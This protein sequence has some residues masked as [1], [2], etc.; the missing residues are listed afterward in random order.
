MNRFENFRDGGWFIRGRWLTVILSLAFV[1]T[2]GYGAAGLYF[3][4][5]YKTFFA[6]DNP[7]RLAYENIQDRFLKSDNVLFVLTA[8]DGD[9]YRPEFLQAVHWLTERAWGLHRATRVDSVT[10]FQHVVADG[11]DLL[12]ADLVD[13][14][15]TLTPE[16][17]REIRRVAESDPLL[18][19][20]LTRLGGNTTGV[21]VTLKL[22][23]SVPDDATRAGE[24]AH[25]MAEEFR[26]KFPDIEMRLTGDTMMSHAFAASSQADAEQII[27]IMYLVIILI[28]WIAL[29][30]IWMTLITVLI[31]VLSSVAM[32]GVAG[33]AGFYLFYEVLH[34]LEHVWRGIGPYG[35]WAR[36][37]HFYH[38]FHNP[39]LNHGV[40]S[41]LWDLVFGTYARPGVI[42]VPE[43]LQMRWL[44]D[45][46]SGS[47]W[48]SLQ[49]QYELRRVKRRRA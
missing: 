6:A 47:V 40:T 30:S 2:V 21:H 13:T 16:L 23:D 1:V 45:P 15:A 9:I 11:D 33:F 36:R 31:V 22:D 8:P 7:E 34:R 35:R 39:R 19:G 24:A 42:K 20:R 48:P 44:V 4:S 38:H 10:N 14:G 18:L 43:K 12:V 37:H 3:N 49:D 5:S 29:R 27:P 46:A 26:A 25:R 32:L 17:Q 28:A 41:P